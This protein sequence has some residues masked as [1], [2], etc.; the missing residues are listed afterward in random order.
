MNTAKSRRIPQ[1]VCIPLSILVFA[2]CAFYTYASM[3]LAPYPGFE[4]NRSRNEVS[5]IEPCHAHQAFCEANQG[6]LQVGDK[7]LTVDGVDFDES[8]EN[9]YKIPFGE[10]RA[11]DSVSIAFLRDG[12]EQTVDWLIVGPSAVGRA[13][14]LFILLLFWFPFWLNGSLVLFVLERRI[15]SRVVCLLLALFNYV[16]AMWLTT[17]AYSFTHVMCNTL[18]E[19]TLVWLIVPIYLHFHLVAPSPLIRRQ[20]RYVFGALYAITAILALL[21]LFQ[22]LPLIAFSLAVLIGFLSSLGVLVFRLVFKPC[23]EDRQVV[24]LMLV[25]IIISFGPG[26]FLSIIPNLLQVTIS[27][28]LASAISWLAIPLLPFFYVYAIFK[29]YLG[30]FESRFRRAL[31]LYSFLLLYVAII[32]AVFYLGSYWLSSSGE[33]G[34]FVLVMWTL[35]GVAA[36]PLYTLFHKLFGWLVYGFAYEPGEVLQTLAVRI[37]AVHG[38]EDWAHIL[39]DELDSRFLVRQSA[40]YL[41]TEE[42]SELIYARGVDLDEG[43]ETLQHIRHLLVD[44][45]RYRPFADDSD[46]DFAWV[47]L[48][49]PLRV[50]GKAI[51]AWLFGQ[52][53][54]ENY[55]S[56]EDIKLLTTLAAQLAA[57]VENDRLYKQA[58]QEIAGRER[59]EEALRESEEMLR[60]ILNATT[61]SVMLVDDKMTILA[62]N[63]TAAQRFGKDIDALVGLQ[64]SG[65]TALGLLSPELYDSRAATLERVLRTGKPAQLEDERN[66]MVFDAYFY[67]VFDADG[68]VRRLAIFAR[69]VTAHRQAEQQVVRA[70]R[71]AAMGQIATALVHEINNPL[72]AIRSN[73]EMLVDFDLGSDESKE[74]L[75]IAVEEIQ[76]LARI[77]RR[78]LE[79][80]Q[81]TQEAPSRVSVT[82]LVRKALALAGEQLELAHIHVKA[83]FPDQS[84]YICVTQSQITQVLLNLIANVSEIVP[85]GGLLDIVVSANGD[86]ARISLTGSGPNFVPGETEHLFDTFYATESV[87]SGLGLWVGRSIVERHGGTITVQSLEDE[88]GLTF[89]VTLPVHS[90]LD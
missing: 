80:T 54:P 27:M 18:V 71:L 36:V 61:E 89:T 46:L 40:L 22:V 19:H 81:S 70:E 68:K 14:R 50:R 13:Y 39:A 5:T 30:S 34:A 11:G 58:L 63:Q 44:A 69:D 49:I 4:W 52:R 55:Y 60:A 32:A 7:I 75:G 90:V 79:F 67:P 17:G 65:L 47:R 53:D 9:L 73:L 15:Q 12:Q 26:I 72:Q 83:N 24:T 56:T 38:S 33:W 6:T 31:D 48:V 87:N 10:Y 59:I 16:T 37:Q 8:T 3:Y 85:D 1:W 66:G 76:H 45:G 21:E 64:I 43:A 25:G 88:R 41:L 57:V 78:V 35:F 82:Q 28:D 86:V 29:R 84:A 23:P 51:G 20:R 42:N 2:V 62:L 77:T 74:R